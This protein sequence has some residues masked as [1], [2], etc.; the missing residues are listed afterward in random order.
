MTDEELEA[1]RADLSE[2]GYSATYDSDLPAYENAR[3]LLA[4]VDRL[5]AE[6][7]AARE[8]R[9]NHTEEAD[10]WRARVARIGQALGM[11][12]PAGGWRDIDN[13]LGSAVEWSAEAARAVVEVAREHY[14]SG[15]HASECVY[16]KAPACTCGRA[17]LQD[18]LVSY[19]ARASGEGT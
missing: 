17:E 13:A 6:L 3:A 12:E 16:W 19:D 9:D 2:G 18:A 4:E 5:R 1:V 10:A 8:D 14:D 15:E 7:E 11:S